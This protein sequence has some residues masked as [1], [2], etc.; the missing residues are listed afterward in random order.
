MDKTFKERNVSYREEIL[1]N[2]FKPKE[3]F[4]NDTLPIKN[5]PFSLALNHK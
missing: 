4:R 5:I 2:Q 1:G 3:Y